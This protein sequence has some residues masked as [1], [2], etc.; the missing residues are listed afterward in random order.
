MPYIHTSDSTRL[1]YREW[2]M[3]T[4][5]LF[6]SAWAFSGAMWEYQ[7]L[8]LSERGLRCIAFD[9]RGHGRSDDPGRG[10]DIDRLSDDL[11]EVIEQLDLRD[12]TLVGNS[13]GCGEIVHYLA[14]HGTSRIARVALVSGVTP[15]TLK[16]AENPQ[17]L[18]K[19]AA[20][21][22]IM[23]MQQDRP[24]YM[25][26]GAIKYFNLGSTWPAAPLLSSEMV[27]WAIRL[28]LECSPKASIECFRISAQTNF[29]PDLRACTVPTLVLHGENDQIAP[30]D[31]CARR[32]VQGIVG[33]ELKTYPGGGHGMFLTHKERLNEDLLTF[34]QG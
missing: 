4:P 22:A 10:F 28:I 25:T 13:M 12:L 20:E 31:M 7:M 33:S 5:V 21:F 1:Y 3:G 17:G 26:D 6:V 19:E 18:P 16:S 9:R 27:Q 29:L 24:L 11:A 2:G 15:G 34:I 30:L 23:K 32:T 8:H 14:R